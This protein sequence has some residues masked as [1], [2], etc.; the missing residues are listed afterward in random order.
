L[1]AS[2]PNSS[3][4]Q[5]FA[6]NARKNGNN[7]LKVTPKAAKREPKIRRG[8]QGRCSGLQAKGKWQERAKLTS[9]SG[10]YEHLFNFG[11]FSLCVKTRAAFE[12]IAKRRKV[13]Y[14]QRRSRFANQNTERRHTSSTFGA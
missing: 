12:I 3:A 2:R 9:K 14:L 6:H 7:E 13:H 10:I 4:G 5:K 1:G 8:V 11:S